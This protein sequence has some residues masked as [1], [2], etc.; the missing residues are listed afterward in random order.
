MP[1]QRHLNNVNKKTKLL[2]IDDHPMTVRGYVM[3][4]ENADTDQEYSIDVAYDSDQVLEKIDAQKRPYDI[5]LLDINLP[6][7]NCKTV[8]SGEDF[9]NHFKK[10]NPNVK[11]IVHTSLNDQQRISNIFNTLNPDGFL[12]K[13]DIDADVLLEAVDAV[14]NGN[15]YYSERTNKLIGT[16]AGGAMHLDAYDRKILYHLSIGE[17][18][19][20]MPHYIPL[21]MPT[22]E[23]RKKNLKALFGVSEGGDLQL[24]QV[25]KKKGFI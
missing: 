1:I 17:K 8:V 15:T 16:Q 18:M 19:K 23:R 12:I 14:L 13:N 21:S 20:N 7:S 9:G 22:I 2:I 10:A 5:V 24:L 6:A 3:V 4:L 25:A 11:I